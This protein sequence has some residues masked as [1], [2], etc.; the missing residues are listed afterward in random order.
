MDDGR[1]RK[2]PDF[3]IVGAAKTGTTALADYL[4]QHPEVFM[5]ATK[6][7]YFFATD[8]QFRP[9]FSHTAGFMPDKEKYLSLYS[10]AHSE[11]RLVDASTW[12]LFSR[13]AARAIK[14]FNPAAK[15][16]ISLRNPVDMIYSL[17]NHW[18]FNLNEDLEDFEEALAAEPDRAKGLRIPPNAFFP[19]G[20]R[21][22]QMPLYCEQVRRY[23]DVFG[24]ENVMVIIFDEMKK[25]IAAMYRQVLAFLEIDPHFQPQFDIVN[26][27]MR[28]R[29]KRLQE[30][31]TN[32]PP[33]VRILAEPILRNWWLRKRIEEMTYLINRKKAP[34]PPM[35]AEVRK[36][37]Q[38]YFAPEVEAL[39]ELL[40]RDLTYWSKG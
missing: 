19:E 27:S 21:Y 39:S 37:L 23:L 35:S 24:R 30:F 20:L 4:G 1:D 34:R 25:D 29:S 5:P 32:P 33:F 36:T 22:R 6:D 12:Y 14:A 7:L 15:I 16:I 26:P 38:A 40:G 28:F 8:L 3:F 9:V 18:I 10:T 13:E 2:I 31:F 17:H 11:K